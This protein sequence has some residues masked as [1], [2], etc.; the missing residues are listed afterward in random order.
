MRPCGPA[1]AV[2][3]RRSA[4]TF[5]GVLY[6]FHRRLT[7]T[8]RLSSTAK[9]MAARSAD[10]GWAWLRGSG[11]PGLRG[12]SWQRQTH[13]TAAKQRWRPPAAPTLPSQPDANLTHSYQY[14]YD[15]MVACVNQSGIRIKES[16]RPLRWTRGCHRSSAVSEHLTANSA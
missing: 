3:A 1:R 8:S 7:S 15:V 10:R 6:F 14:C 4:Q 2:L 13:L 11:A 9:C 5:M 16:D 12:T